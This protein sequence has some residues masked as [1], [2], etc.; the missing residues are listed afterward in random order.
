MDN[1]IHLPR[2]FFDAV[3]FEPNEHG[4]IVQTVA[5]RCFLLPEHKVLGGDR[6]FSLTALLNRSI[7]HGGKWRVMFC[8]PQKSYWHKHTRLFMRHIPT[9]MEMHWLDADGDVKVVVECEDDPWT[10]VDQ[11]IS[12][13]RDACEEAWH[14]MKDILSKVDIQEYQTFKQAKGQ[15]THGAYEDAPLF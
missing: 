11:G 3:K 2:A 14:E 6:T 4:D 5:G 1:V 7:A 8:N 15:K 13:Y 12:F 10:I 9:M